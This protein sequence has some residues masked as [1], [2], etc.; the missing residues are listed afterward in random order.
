MR[1]ALQKL[2]PQQQRAIKLIYFDGLTPE[3]VS[4][5]RSDRSRCSAQS[6]PRNR[7]FTQFAFYSG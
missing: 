6:V 5:D 7:R 2:K 4:T 1:E 3:E